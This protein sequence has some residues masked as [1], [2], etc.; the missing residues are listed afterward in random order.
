MGKKVLNAI[1]GLG[2]LLLIVNV[3]GFFYYTEVP[4][5]HPAREDDFPRLVSEEAEFWEA[6]K[7]G[8]DETPAVY[9]GRM[10]RLVSDRF[11][12]IDPA[13]VKPTFFE[14]WILWGIARNRGRYEWFNLRRAVRAGG[15]YG[16]QH[17][18]VFNGLMRRAGL[19]SRILG[20][21]GHVLNEVLIDGQ[22][23]VYDP[24]Y[25]VVF[26]DSL[27]DLVR[28]PEKITRAYVAAGRP[29]EEAKHWREVL[30]SPADNWH[31]P[32]R[33]LYD[34]KGYLVETAALYLVW[35]IPLAFLLISGAGHVGFRRRRG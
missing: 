10:A 29:V 27:S 22:W 20:V 5:D 33:K 15:G 32:S 24:D 25:N 13:H 31:Y 17:A 12:K 35:L 18:M 2:V 3:A 16:S 14:N 6:A 19:T 4:E 23:R 1:G 34:V 11:V 21:G 8:A 26:T 30:A 9:A 28:A 7:K